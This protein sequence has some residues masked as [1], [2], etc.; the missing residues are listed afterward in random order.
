MIFTKITH[1]YVAQRFDQ[2]GKF[3][4]QK[5]VAGDPVEYESEHGIID[6]T[7][8]PLKGAEYHRFE[9]VQADQ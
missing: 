2:N 4:D 1:G 8:M 9:M 6:A 7:D 5:F 3:L